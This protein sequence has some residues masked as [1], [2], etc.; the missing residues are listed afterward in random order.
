MSTFLVLMM[1]VL[2]L[3]AALP[4]FYFSSSHKAVWHIP[5]FLAAYSKGVG[6]SP[7]SS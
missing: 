1:V 4:E 7:A 3:T 5:Y 6:S 2:Q